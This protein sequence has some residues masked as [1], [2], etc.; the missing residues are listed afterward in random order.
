MDNTTKNTNNIANRYISE[1]AVVVSFNRDTTVR[2]KQPKAEAAFK[3]IINKASMNTNLPDD[4]DPSNPRII[5]RDTF[6]EIVISQIS[7]TLLARFDNL[8]SLNKQVEAIDENVS[9]LFNCVKEF[10]GEANIKDTGIIVL[11]KH[12]S[13]KPVKELNS[14]L[15]NNFSKFE[16]Q[17]EIVNVNYRM[18]FKTDNKLF[19]GYDLSTYETINE[20]A[21]A[22]ESKKNENGYI[23]RI[24]LNNKPFF[25]DSKI[26]F[27]LEPNDIK[28][29]FKEVI[30]TGIDNFLKNSLK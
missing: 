10:A 12:T 20:T 26:A 24:E 15:F 5:F 14:Y 1:A 11:V 27:L 8:E 28:A 16:S 6:K 7:A 22:A 4:S 21:A 25:I 17:G 9:K 29:K 23:V 3:N 30:N 2:L 19:V 18:G 13:D